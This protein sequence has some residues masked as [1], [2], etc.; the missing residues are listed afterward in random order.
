MIDGIRIMEASLQLKPL[1]QHNIVV[2]DQRK[3]SFALSGRN[4]L[5]TSRSKATVHIHA[6]TSNL[7]AAEAW[8]KHRYNYCSP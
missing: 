1:S 5:R 4:G 3:G 2:N 7:I 8:E 6:I